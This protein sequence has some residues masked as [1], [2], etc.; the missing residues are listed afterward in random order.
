MA[1]LCFNKREEITVFILSFSGIFDLI[2]GIAMAW[3]AAITINS[4]K[5]EIR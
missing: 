4:K 5:G 3:A 2:L 1:V